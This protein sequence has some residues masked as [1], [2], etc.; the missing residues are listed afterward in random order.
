MC[1][2]AYSYYY[3]IGAQNVKTNPSDMLLKSNDT[4]NYVGHTTYN[5]VYKNFDEKTAAAD[6]NE[7]AIFSDVL[8]KIQEFINPTG[9]D[10]TFA[11]LV[12][13]EEKITSNTW[14]MT[15]FY[16]DFFTDKTKTYVIGSL[17]QSDDP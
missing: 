3:T 8:A 6:E 17:P 5:G 13:P 14:Y 7:S 2:Y 11:S 4:S 15:P 9:G 1:S 16:P 12:N 10:S